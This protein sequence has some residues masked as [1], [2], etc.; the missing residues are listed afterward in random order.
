[1]HWAAMGRGRGRV[2]CVSGSVRAHVCLGPGVSA[3]P[4]PDPTHIRHLLSGDDTY[5]QPVISAEG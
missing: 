5:V 2:R 1:M 4:S 3:S